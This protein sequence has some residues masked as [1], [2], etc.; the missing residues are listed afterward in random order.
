M[1]RS[2][3]RVLMP[4]TRRTLLRGSATVGLGAALRS[5]L[6][7]PAWAAAQN[8]GAPAATGADRTFDLDIRRRGVRIGG[9]EATPILINESLPGPLL[10][11]REGETVVIKVA[12]ALDEVASIHWHGLLVPYDMDGVPGVSFPG[13]G[14]GE[15][16]TYRFTLRQ[17][18]T[19]WYHS[20]SGNQEQL[21]VYGPLVVDPSEPEPFAY[22]REHVVMFSDW[23][24]ED[25]ARVLAKLKKDPSYYNFQQRTVA[26]L[27]R[28]AA[29]NG[30]R[31]TLAE[32]LTWGRMRMNPT[33][34]ADVT[35]YT[36][37]YLV[38][39]RVPD[40][41]W[42]ALFAPGER[43]RLRFINAAAMTHFD[44]RIP[45]LEMT[46]VQADGQNV[47]PVAVEEFRIAP[48]ETYDAIVRPPRADAYTIFAEAMD[49]SGYAAGSLATRADV[50]GE[51]PPRRRRP[52]R[53]MADMGMADMPGTSGMMQHDG[54]M[55]TS[56]PPAP[57]AA[58]QPA[59]GGEHG[60]HP[61]AGT[62][63][64][65]ASRMTGDT[66]MHGPDTHGPGN[67]MVAMAPRRRLD[68]PGTG[69]DPGERRVLVYRDLRR[70]RPAEDQRPPAREIEMHLTGNMERQMWSINGKKYSEARE[71]IPLRFGERVRITLVNDTMMDHPMHLH[72]MWMVLD[73][74][75]GAR[76]P[77]KHTINVK[78]GERLSFIV[79]PDER[80][81]FAFH[82]HLLFHMELGML[83]V[84]SVTDETGR[85]RS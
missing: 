27:L 68:E 75:T 41:H 2:D 9:R 34:I 12:N 81:P 51:I 25:P 65:E 10:R 43:V 70:L 76:M 58:P 63:A 55:A 56:V 3:N 8:T 67:S 61:G 29:R 35:G 16:F 77:Y 30:W 1:S 45:G 49:R 36:Y 21:G 33:D 14:P 62:P 52:V 46:L 4:L 59:P 42:T 83:R 71:P 44:V 17:S 85:A 60:G 57:P 28:D 19:Y 13:I 26:D 38:N 50:R 5:V 32:R 39:G 66:A 64:T 73:N 37:T 15:A 84:V 82:C 69:L 24:F 47:Q 48:A 40:E 20:H 74:G 78:A 7:L 31:A 6:P 22:D 79:T 80:G 53:T 11:F 54:A 18:G 23:T 72:G